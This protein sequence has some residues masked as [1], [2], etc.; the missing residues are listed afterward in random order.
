MTQKLRVKSETWEG[1]RFASLLEDVSKTD[2]QKVL[3]T[4]ALLLL[5]SLELKASTAAP[6]AAAMLEEEGR[7]KC[8]EGGVGDGGGRRGG[9]ERIREREFEFKI[10]VRVK[11]NEVHKSV[12]DVWRPLPSKLTTRNIIKSLIIL[13]FYR[14]L[15]RAT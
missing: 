15:S 2:A 6:R 9:R 11:P 10:K 4:F 1:A 8:L 7:G 14:F 5:L 3:L 13:L 12:R